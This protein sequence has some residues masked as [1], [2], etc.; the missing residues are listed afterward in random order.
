MHSALLERFAGVI[1]GGLAEWLVSAATAGRVR[2]DVTAAD[3]TEAIAGITLLG[4]LTRAQELDAAWVDRTT[5]LLLKG[6]SA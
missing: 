4:L 1:S 6:I 5:G 3:L 2:T